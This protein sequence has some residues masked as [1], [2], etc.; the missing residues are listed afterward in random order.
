[1]RH[2]KIVQFL[3]LAK[4]LASNAEGLSLDDMADLLGA[5]RRTAERMRDAIRLVFPNMEELVDGRTKRFRIS[6][7]LDAFI[8]SPTAEE[9]AELGAAALALENGGASV[10]AATLRSLAGKIRS[11]QRPNIRRRVDPDLEVLRDTQH[12]ASFPHVRPTVSTKTLATLQKALLGSER[13]KFEY[14]RGDGEKWTRTVDPF[15]FLWAQPA[16]YLVGPESGKEDPVLWRLDRIENAELGECFAG[17]PEHFSMES[18]AARSFGVFQEEP[19]RVRIRFDA[20][21]AD[22]ARS[23]FFHG[24]QRLTDLDDGSLEVTFSAGGLVEVA[25]HVMSWGG[26]AEALEPAEL[27]ALLLAEVDK[28]RQRHLRP[29]GESPAVAYDINSRALPA[30]TKHRAPSGKNAGS[31]RGL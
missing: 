20:S 2:Y 5:D 30:D 29:S 16:S 6:G 24:D 23:Y 19:R 10:R 27:R 13:V 12:P 15:G 9:L 22:V 1:M 3:D 17:I 21:V 28:L 8:Q 11:A 18:Y 14:T 31:Q 26:A 25:R 7:G 4:A